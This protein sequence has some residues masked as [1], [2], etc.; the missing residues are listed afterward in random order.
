MEAEKPK[1]ETKGDNPEAQAYKRTKR[2]AA[3]T[4]RV[5]A[6]EHFFLKTAAGTLLTTLK[7]IETVPQIPSLTKAWVLGNM[8]KET[9]ANRFTKATA[10]FVKQKEALLQGLKVFDNKLQKRFS[11][12]AF[13]A[14]SGFVTAGLVLLV[15]PL[16]LALLPPK[17]GPGHAAPKEPAK[18]AVAPSVPNPAPAI[19]QWFDLSK[20]GALARKA[21][22][23][24]VVQKTPDPAQ[25]RGPAQ[26][27]ASAPPPSSLHRPRPEPQSS[28]I[29]RHRH[30]T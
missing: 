11:P 17:R 1:E 21:E 26:G 22:E 18:E 5:R 13:A 2:E 30:P 29:F 24:P 9:W 12:L 15:S 10:F 6:V 14:L 7:T 23:P 3:R 19:L 16:L 28:R 8:K 27:S 25:G 4:A 20:T